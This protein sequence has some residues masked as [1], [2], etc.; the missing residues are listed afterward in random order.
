V[1]N[2][3]DLNG[4]RQ[5]EILGHKDRPQFEHAQFA[6][7]AELSK[8]N[9]TLCEERHMN[10]VSALWH[11]QALD[12]EIDEKTKRAKQVEAALS[13]DPALA[14]T[15]AAFESEQK[16]LA[17]FRAA[18][19]DR[20]LEASSLDEKIKGIEERLY[21][22][23]VSNPKELDG[24]EKDRQMHR[25]QRGALDEVRLGL[26]DSVEQ[27]QK[28]LDEQSLA[29]KQAESTRAAKLDLLTSERASLESRLNELNTEREMA[30]TALAADALRTYDHLQRTKVGRAVAQIKRDAC[31]ACGVATPTG[32]V[33]RV[34]EG[35]EI[36]FCSGC[37]RIL[38]G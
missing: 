38:A 9:V 36:V 26:M 34:H 4:I 2:F 16:Q 23:R 7:T 5:L 25:R 19:H 24:M 35:N 10:L 6:Q 31:G 30:R 12:Q 13:N 22:G 1:N 8:M 14:A 27:S 32:L 37:G 11:L 20:E 33:Q 28:H 15:R 17:T 29:L 21:G 18:L 3:G